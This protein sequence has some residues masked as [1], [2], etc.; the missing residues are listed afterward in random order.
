MWMQSKNAS[1]EAEGQVE[2]RIGKALAEGAQWRLANVAKGNRDWH[3]RK[4]MLTTLS[5]SLAWLATRAKAEQ[6]PAQ[7]AN[8]AASE[9]ASAPLHRRPAPGSQVTVLGGC[10]SAIFQ[11]P[12]L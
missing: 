6:S 8:E 5:A 2:E 4:R 12:I 3:L 11:S 7:S 10:G 9:A 1:W